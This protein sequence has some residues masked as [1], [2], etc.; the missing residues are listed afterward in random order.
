MNWLSR[1][2]GFRL[3]KRSWLL[4][5]F[6]DSYLESLPFSLALAFL[7][8]PAREK[9]FQADARHGVNPGSNA[10]SGSVDGFTGIERRTAQPAVLWT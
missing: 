1:V 10:G 6:Y 8:R 3:S 7:E 9:T 5:W 4:S 2:P